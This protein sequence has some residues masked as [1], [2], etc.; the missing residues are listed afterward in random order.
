MTLRWE[1][2]R[3]QLGKV[4][5]DIWGD[6]RGARGYFNGGYNDDS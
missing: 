6:P 3:S 1:E 4:E 5:R 2:T